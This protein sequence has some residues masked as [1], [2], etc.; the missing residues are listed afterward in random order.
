MAYGDEDEDEDEG[1][2]AKAVAGLT[3]EGMIAGY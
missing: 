3:T 1:N 2:G